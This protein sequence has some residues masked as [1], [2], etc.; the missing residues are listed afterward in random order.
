MV[1]PIHIPR[2]DVWPGQGE[3]IHRG[4]NHTKDG[5]EYIEVQFSTV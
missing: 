2:Q 3:G 4:V 1:E 5:L